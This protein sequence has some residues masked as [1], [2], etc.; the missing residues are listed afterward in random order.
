MYLDVAEAARTAKLRDHERYSRE[1]AA[2]LSVKLTKILVV[3]AD[4]VRA[5]PGLQI[6]RDGQ[7][8]GEGAYGTAVAVDPGKHQVSVSAPGY[9]RWTSEVEAW[10][11]GATVTSTVP[12]LQPEPEVKPVLEAGK[13]PVAPAPEAGAA[14][15]G[16]WG[17]QRIAAVG[18][19]GLGA[20]ALVAGIT[21]GGMALSSKSEMDAQCT[22]GSPPRCNDAGIAAHA[23]AKTLGIVSTGMFVGAGVLA[24]AGVVLW[25]TAPIAPPSEPTKTGQAAS[26]GVA[27][28]PGGASLHGVW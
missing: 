16:F 2:A 28:G 8:V 13:T 4:E 12:K 17:P 10:G 25:V 18:A 1:R 5:I 21:T 7:L 6:L 24:A 23:D 11:E 22:A 14:G 26:L 15:G 19:A 27:I 9:R 20:G 3:V